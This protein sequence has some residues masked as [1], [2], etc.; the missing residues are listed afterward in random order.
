M[1]KYLASLLLLLPIVVSAA[2]FSIVVYNHDQEDTK[3][4]YSVSTVRALFSSNVFIPAVAANKVGSANWNVTDGSQASIRLDI[5]DK[6]QNA[7]GRIAFLAEATG[8]PVLVKTS[9]I[10]NYEP[11]VYKITTDPAPEKNLQDTNT[12]AIHIERKR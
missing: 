4:S 12:L 5:L 6:N 11:S 1:L 2:D 7:I 10:S 8:I 3:T 9:M